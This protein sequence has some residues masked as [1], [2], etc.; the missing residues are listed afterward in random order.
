MAVDVIAQ[1]IVGISPRI[2][3]LRQQVAQVATSDHPVLILGESGSGKEVVARAIHAASAR[4][5]APFVGQSCLAIPETLIES[6]LFGYEPGAFTDARER[7]IGLFEQAEGGTLFLDEI[8]DIPLAFQKRLL[9]VLQEREVR[10][11][12]SVVAIAINV[13]IIAA[14]NAP[15][16][17]AV[18]Q[19]TFRSDLL[20]RLNT[21][22]IR[23]PPLRQRA[24]DVPLL[25]EH[26]IAKHGRAYGFAGKP[27]AALLK[28][29]QEYPWPGNVRELEN[30]VVRWMTLGDE[31]LDVLDKKLA[32]SFD[33]TSN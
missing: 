27:S 5:A 25:V 13:R 1:R 33:T 19:G 12:G 28:R 24:E 21:F 9:R 3:T 7:R 6:E 11:L 10:R 29:L 15:I 32:L 20:Y 16:E 8:G 31:A 23:V 22:E 14:T 30:F 18:A 4:H 2:R 17:Q 26:F